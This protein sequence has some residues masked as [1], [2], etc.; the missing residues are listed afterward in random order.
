MKKIGLFFGSFNPIHIGH[1]ILANYI[2]ENSDMDELWFVVSPQNPFKD[3][4]TLLSDHN[5][6]D[7]VQLAVKNYPNMRASNIEFSLPKPSYTVDTLTYLHEKYP[8]HSFSLIM[9]EDNLGSLHKW[10]NAD[11]LVEN[12]HIIVYPR[13]FE[14]AKK[15]SVYGNHTNISMIKAPVI[16]LSATEIRAMIREGKNVRPMLPPEVFEYLDGSSFYK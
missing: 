16:E 13:V 8:E 6:L 14:G 11:L 5:R 10:K 3:K 4:K 15:E 1:L 9:G 2:L 12:H 7:M